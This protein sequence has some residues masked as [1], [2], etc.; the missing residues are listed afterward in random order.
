M[1]SLNAFLCNPPSRARAIPYRPHRQRRLKKRRV[2]V[3]EKIHNDINRYVDDSSTLRSTISFLPHTIP[4]AVV[5]LPNI[6]NV[7]DMANFATTNDWT[8]TATVATTDSEEADS[9]L[10]DDQIKF[11]DGFYRLTI[12]DDR[13]LDQRASKSIKKQEPAEETRREIQVEEMLAAEKEIEV[14]EEEEEE[15]KEEEEEEEEDKEDEEDE[16]DEEEEKWTCAQVEKKIIQLCMSWINP[17]TPKMFGTFSDHVAAMHV[18]TA[19]NRL[20]HR[21]L[22]QHSSQ[23]LLIAQFGLNVGFLSTPR[24]PLLSCQVSSDCIPS[25]LPPGHLFQTRPRPYS[26]GAA[27]FW[28]N[29][30][31]VLSNDGKDIVSAL[32]SLSK[33]ATTFLVEGT[34]TDL[35]RKISPIIKRERNGKRHLKI[36][37]RKLKRAFKKATRKKKGAYPLP[38]LM[39]MLMNSFFALFARP[40]PMLKNEEIAPSSSI[41]HVHVNGV[42]DIDV[43]RW[44]DQN[45]SMATNGDAVADVHKLIVTKYDDKGK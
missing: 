10:D 33:K 14:D 9:D 16:E 6:P 37:G 21:G 27:D 23:S 19:D 39:S 34:A 25:C 41:V 32:A 24:S 40:A 36:I 1:E 28:I 45:T 29:I 5:A 4:K 20:F 22:Y 8:D 38:K 12:T 11:V 17:K 30:L 13:N 43:V 31:Q 7:Q 3:R 26:L 42:I 44:L 35:K 18:K 15:E 2:T